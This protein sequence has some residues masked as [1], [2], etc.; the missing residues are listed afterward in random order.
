VTNNTF[1]KLIQVKSTHNKY[2][3]SVIYQRKCREFSK[4][5]IGQTRQCFPQDFLE[6]IFI[7]PKEV[8]YGYFLYKSWFSTCDN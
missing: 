2:F 7:C 4:L 5:Y 6:N 8:R 1:G 3:L